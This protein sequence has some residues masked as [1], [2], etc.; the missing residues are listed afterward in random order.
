ML[1]VDEMADALS[2][3]PKTVKIWAA[4]GL[5]R[6]HAYSDKPEHLCERPGRD[7]PKKAQ[8]MKLSSR[9]LVSSVT[10]ECCNEAQYE[11]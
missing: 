9:G 6:A 1:T 5:L 11:A 7:A 10:L 3:N 8:G 2:V 4:H